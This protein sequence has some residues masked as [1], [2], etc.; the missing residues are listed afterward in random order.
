MIK[1]ILFFLTYIALFFSVIGYGLIIARLSKLTLAGDINIGIKPILGIIFLSFISYV[2]I[3]FI[4]HGILF[5]SL[6]HLVGIFLFFKNFSKFKEF[7]DSSNIIIILLLFISLIISKTHDDFSFYHLQQSLNFSQNK[8]Q[9][10]LSN[11]D[12]SYSHHSSLLYLNSIFYLPFYKFLLFNIPNHII[13]TSVILA[14]Y[15]FS[16]DVKNESFLRYYSLISLIFIIPKFTRLAEFGTDTS[17]QLLI[18]LFFYFIFKFFLVTNLQQ[19]KEIIILTGLLLIYCITLKTYFILYALVFLYIAFSYN[20]F[21]FFEIF[22]NSFFITFFTILFITSFFLLNLFTSGCIIYPFP[23][24]CFENLSWALSIDEI[25][26]YQIWYE[27]WAKSLAGAGYVTEG[28][29]E[30]IGGFSWIPIWY[31]NYFFGRF[32]ENIILLIFI[33]SIFLFIF[34]EQKIIKKLSLNVFLS[35]YFLIVLIVFVW[36]FKH[37][38]LR[39]GGYAPVFLIF[40]LPTSFYLSGFIFH[41]VKFSKYSNIL[42]L[43]VL[44]FFVSKNFVRINSEIVRKD[45]YKFTNFPFFSVPNVEYQKINITDEISV[46]KPLAN[47][48][49]TTPAPCPYSEGLYAKKKIGFVIFYKNKR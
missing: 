48:C 35:I 19:K 34:K 26:D 36:F 45:I 28:Y 46:Y 37:P 27:A 22:T 10:G 7:K 44:S 23:L 30:I 21:K 8:F 39:Y 41:N 1:I 3:F 16:K 4:P 20:I 5:N 14:F 29:K 40:S 42:L 15:N 18:L 25:K 47:N 9:I 43:V 24:L 32:S 38:A 2:T 6:I 17:G 31:K 12:F 11:L 13:F 49:W 33:N